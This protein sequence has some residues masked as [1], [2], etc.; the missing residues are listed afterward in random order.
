MRRKRVKKHFYKDIEGRFDFQDVYSAAV[1]KAPR[2]AIF[3]EI[4]TWQGKSAAYLSVEAEN[5]GKNIEIHCID[6][7][8]WL[9][10]FDSVEELE[11][12]C[13]GNLKNCS[14]ITIHRRKSTD[15]PEDVLGG[16]YADFIYIDANHSYE[17]V[18]DDIATWY[19]FL[20]VGGV[21]AGHDY[22]KRFT[23]LRCAVAEAFGFNYTTL[24]KSWVHR[25]R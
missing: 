24:Y 1:Q 25:K 13:R 23:G 8:T 5:S 17:A 6:S 7:F 11:K 2:N 10:G 15:N 14:N 4:G 22:S 16:E 20:R 3:V 12:A 18:K 21:M 9:N 19:P